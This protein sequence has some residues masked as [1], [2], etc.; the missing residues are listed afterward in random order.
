MPGSFNL[1]GVHDPVVDKLIDGVI[2][3]K[4]RRTLVT[5]TRALDR[6]LL[7]GHYVIPQW[8]I[9]G[10]RLAFWNK[11]GRPKVTPMQGYQFDT[12]WVDA[13]RETAL[14]ARKAVVVAAGTKK[15][16]TEKGWPWG[17]IAAG[18]TGL[19][20]ILVLVRRRRKAQP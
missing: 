10:D 16:P 18:A 20:L 17:W 7:W 12:W 19:V 13:A 6:V 2:A 5:Y 1:A 15:A 4:D 3:A 11:F 14:N 8:H 9:K